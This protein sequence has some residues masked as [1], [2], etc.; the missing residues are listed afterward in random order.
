MSLKKVVDL[1][2]KHRS[3]L[4]TVHTNPEGDALGSELAF[5]MMLKKLGKSATIINE[6]D[7]PY[8]YNFL[9]GQNIIKKFNRR[10]FSESK[11]ANSRKKDLRNINFDCFAVLD[12]SDLARTGE[13]HRLNSKDMPIINIDHHISND[14]FGD[15]NWV[16]PNASSTSEMIYALY[17]SLRVPFDKDVALLLYVGMLTDT[18]SF[19]YTNTNKYTH[20]AVSELLKYNL[21]VTGTYKHIYENI[22]FEDIKLLIRILPNIKRELGGKIIWFQI[23]QDVLKNKKLSFDLSEELLSFA[24]AIKDVE[25]AV[26]FKENLGL[27]DEI[28]VNFRSQG[29]VDVNKIANLFGG[30]GH[31]TASGATVRGRIDQVRKKVLAKIKENLK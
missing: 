30:G 27:K 26:L 4:I 5:Y 10:F 18:G 9:P 20:M 7:V 16:D 21:D 12:C 28:R 24:R 8:G 3:F 29:R 2:K 17:K 22:P 14:R 23:K 13:I 11:S 19:R 25:V 6:D 15:A 31:R 1:I